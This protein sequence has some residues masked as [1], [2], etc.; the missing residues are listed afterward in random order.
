MLFFR[1]LH[2]SPVVTFYLSIQGG[3]IRILFIWDM[4]Q[5]SYDRSIPKGSKKPEIVIMLSQLNS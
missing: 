2:S 1:N 5:K 4:I 3:K